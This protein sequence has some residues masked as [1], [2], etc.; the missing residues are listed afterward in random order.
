[1]V[2]ARQRFKE[3]GSADM[4]LGAALLILG[5]TEPARLL[6]RMPAYQWQIATDRSPSPEAFRLVEA[7][8]AN[9]WSDSHHFLGLAVQKL[10]A[11]GRAA[12]IVAAYDGKDR[13]HLAQLAGNPDDRAM[14][15]EFGPDMALALRK[16]G[17]DQEA[18]ALLDR[19][20]RLVRQVYAKGQVPD[21]F[22]AQAAKLW[23]AQGHH[24]EAI[25]ALRRAV[26]R[27]WRYESLT[28]LPDIGNLYA[29]R[30]LRGDAG[31][32][33]IR[34]RLRDHLQKERE[35]LGPAPV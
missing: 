18:M 1:M 25:A 11:S 5:Y 8:S 2:A 7:N 33:Q 31:F 10:L 4:K 15:V 29:F 34:L 35:R 22:D 13:G 9:D 32:E 21:W 12:E 14:V 23:A 27:G 3:P 16:V 28:P 26:D 24:E 17:R 6:M 19:T 30:A 20:E